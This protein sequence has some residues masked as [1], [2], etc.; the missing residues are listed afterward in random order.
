PTVT[1]HSVPRGG[2]T[3]MTRDAMTAP[4]RQQLHQ[5]YAAAVP[6][7]SVPWQ[8]DP[9]ARPELAWLNEQLPRELGY[10]PQRL[11][12]PA[13]LA[14]LTGQLAPHGAP[15]ARGPAAHADAEA[16]STAQ[17]CAGHHFGTPNPQLGDGR[18]VLLGDLFDTCGAP[19]DLHLKGSGPTP[20]ARAGDGK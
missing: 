14:L 17:V 6:E 5:T 12:S 15:L 1:W 9:P 18:A 13:G 3:S 8:A 7:L 16:F 11:R 19:R 20:F 2:D 10:E 4:P